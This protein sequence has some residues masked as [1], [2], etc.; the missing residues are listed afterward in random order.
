M[1]VAQTYTVPIIGSATAFGGA[2]I[3]NLASFSPEPPLI[4]SIEHETRYQYSSPVTH[5]KHL[6]RLQPVHDISQMVLSYKFTISAHS[7]QV[8]NFSGAFGNYASFLEIKEPY[9]ELVSLSQSIVSMSALPRKM[10]LVHQPRTMPLIWMPWDRVMMEA[11]L[12]PPELAESEMF[13]LS[14]YAMSFVRKNNND[15]F[16]VLKDINQTIFKEYAYAAGSTTL[17]TTPYEVYF[18]RQGV[19]QDFANLLICLARLLDIPARYR[20]GYL[21][22]GGG[23]ETRAE[24]DAS[25]AW[26]EVFLPY[27]GW[28]GFDPTNG[29]MAERDHIRVACGRH[30]KDATPTSGAIF[31]SE[32][33]AL[34]Q[35]T[36]TTSVKVTRLN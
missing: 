16:E 29:C 26:V 36:L 2:P 20:V 12:Q 18:N 15:A 30:Y 33:E 35:E 1:I 3:P 9:T 13:E 14:D 34:V 23:Y 4:Y 22:T 28:V 19:C 31:E 5:S 7:A 6:F 11:Y 24:A 21:Y 25:H 8:S 27:I 10:D 17:A 32:G